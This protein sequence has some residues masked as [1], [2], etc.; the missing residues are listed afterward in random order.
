MKALLR[1]SIIAL[2]LFGGY[3]AFCSDAATS[4][5]SAPQLPGPCMPPQ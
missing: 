4:K 5:L 3:S 2:I 1:S